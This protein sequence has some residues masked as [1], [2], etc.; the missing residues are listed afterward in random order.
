MA[1]SKQLILGTV[2]LGMTYG[3]NNQHGKPSL[4]ESIAILKTAQTK[5][6][7]TIDTADQYGESY[8]IINQFHKSNPQFKVMSKF[9]LSSSVKVALKE[10]LEKLTVPSLFNYSFHSFKDFYQYEN[11]NEIKELKDSGLVQN[12]GVSIYTNEEFETAIKSDIIDII[13]TPFNLLD[14]FN[15]RGSL[16]NKAKA[17]NKK[18]H[19]RSVFLQGLFFKKDLPAK[20]D[21]LKQPLDLLCSIS[22]ENKMDLDELALRYCLSFPEIDGVLHWCR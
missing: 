3:I 9:K 15:F 2:Q 5:G 1:D 4:D 21:S 19:V 10:T 11:F 6:I 8:Q 17:K 7:T 18:I 20:L 14:N 13:Q 16:L 12:F 22:K